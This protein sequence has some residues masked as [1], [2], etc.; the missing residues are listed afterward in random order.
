MV[1]LLWDS[2]SLDS[3]D[4]YQR[5]CIWFIIGM[6]SPWHM[7]PDLPE[8]LWVYQS[9]WLARYSCNSILYSKFTEFNYSVLHYW[10]RLHLYWTPQGTATPKSLIVYGFTSIQIRTYHVVDGQMGGKCCEYL[11]KRPIIEFRLR[12]TQWFKFFRLTFYVA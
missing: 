1:Y 12:I 11:K 7:W 3:Y 9:E 8:N 5:H 6:M 4:S 2:N 10:H